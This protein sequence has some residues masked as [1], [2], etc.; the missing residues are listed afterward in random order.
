MTRMMPLDEIRILAR[1]HAI[2]SGEQQRQPGINELDLRQ[3]KGHISS[4]H[5]AFVQQVV[6]DVEQRGVLGTED[7]LCFGRTV[8]PRLFWRNSPRRNHW[9][10][11]YAGHGPVSD[12]STPE[13]RSSRVR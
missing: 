4:E 5:H 1:Q 2:R 3:A 12:T 6:D 13:P 7:L 9:M 11:L 8:W 10:K